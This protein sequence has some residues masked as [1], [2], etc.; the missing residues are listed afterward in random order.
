MTRRQRVV[1][2][3]VKYGEQTKGDKV[4]THYRVQIFDH[5][6]NKQ[7]HRHFSI[8]KFGKSEAYKRAKSCLH[9]LREGFK[10]EGVVIGEINEKV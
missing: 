8:E 1:T 4:Y 10:G 2:G 7:I 9:K 6:S 5:F 3:S